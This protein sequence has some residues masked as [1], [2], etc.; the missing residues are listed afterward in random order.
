VISSSIDN[1]FVM[2]VMSAAA[3]AAAAA[4]A[5]A[6]AAAADADADADAIV[7]VVAAN[8]RKILDSSDCRNLVFAL[9]SLS[10]VFTCLHIFLLKLS[11]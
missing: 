5:D 10:Q 6:D 4:D 7:V 8:L 9:V 11:N 1:K 2:L 3:A